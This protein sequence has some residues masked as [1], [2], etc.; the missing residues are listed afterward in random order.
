MRILFVKTSSLG[1]VVHNCPAVSDLRRAFPDAAID[2][3]V[4]ESFAEVVALHG[5]VRRTIPV[6]I[7]R[8]RSRLLHPETWRE[9]RDFRRDLRAEPYDLVIDSQGLLK[10]AVISLQAR[11]VRHGYDADSVRE[12]LASRFYDVRHS[13]S[14][15]LH[16]VERN[17]M[18]AGMAAGRGFSDVCDYGLAAPAA[19]PIATNKPFCVLLSMTS[20]ADKLWP[21]AYWVDL[22]RSLKARGFTCV[23]PWGS[24]TEHDR[25]SRIASRAGCGIVPRALSLGELAG[26][27]SHADAVFGVDT[28]LAHLAVALGTRAFG[29][30][31]STDPLRTGLHGS[32]RMV[33][34]GGPG[35]IP[36]P[37]E[38]MA[39]MEHLV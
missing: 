27:L 12:K 31:C 8:W 34:L 15:N 37:A 11:G 22:A 17:R 35:R 5:A 38:A 9:I 3:V 21:E 29:I 32:G 13:V 6:A 28:G 2:W 23:L 19:D 39:A 30:Y 1:D 7:R 14:R 26:V 33:N 4:E 24:A 25:C 16:A 18:L 36:L 20:R 10:S